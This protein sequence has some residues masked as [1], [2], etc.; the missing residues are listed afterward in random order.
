MGHFRICGS[1]YTG[2]LVSVDVAV[3]WVALLLSPEVSSSN[4]ARGRVRSV[5]GFPMSP[6]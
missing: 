1:L 5:V 2:I 6:L 3:E 4:L